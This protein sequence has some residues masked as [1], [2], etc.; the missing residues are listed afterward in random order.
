MNK[1]HNLMFINL[2]QITKPQAK[3]PRICKLECK[4]NK[5]SLYPRYIIFL[6]SYCVHT[7]CYLFS[8]LVKL[9]Q[10]NDLTDPGSRSTGDCSRVQPK[11]W[12]DGGDNREKGN[13]QVI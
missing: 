12:G 8:L 9:S 3:N 6:L 4:K 10:N 11:M 13:L 2:G 5:P 1:W 7:L